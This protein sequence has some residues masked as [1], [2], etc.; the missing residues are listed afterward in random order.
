MA[1]LRDVKRGE[2]EVLRFGGHHFTHTVVVRDGQWQ[3]RRL[4]LDRAKADAYLREHGMFMPE[5]A[6]MLSEPG[7]E[8]LLQAGSRDGLIAAVMAGEWPIR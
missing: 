4:V 5:H 2:G 6:E 8:V 1:Q 7:E 3:V